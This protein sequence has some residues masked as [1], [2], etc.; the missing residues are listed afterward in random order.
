MVTHDFYNVAKLCRPYLLLEN[1]TVREQSG[2]HIAR[3]FIKKYFESDILR[4]SA[5][6]WKRKCGSMHCSEMV[7]GKKQRTYCRVSDKSSN[8]KRGD[9]YYGEKGT[10]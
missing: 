2:R 8:E 7:S 9:L 3:V 1:G 5:S 6:V 4:Q 10:L